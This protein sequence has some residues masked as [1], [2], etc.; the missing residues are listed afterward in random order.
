MKKGLTLIGLVLLPGLSACPLDSL[1]GVLSDEECLDILAGF[2]D[3]LLPSQTDLASLEGAE[4]ICA[5]LD[6]VR[7]GL[8]G[9]CCPQPW[10]GSEE[11]VEDSEGLCALLETQLVALTAACDEVECFTD[12]DCDDSVFCNGPE[13]CDTQTLQCMP[14]ESPCQAD[15][16]CDEATANCVECLSDPDCDDAEFCNGPE[17]CDTQTSQCLAGTPPCIAACDEQSQVCGPTDALAM[18]VDPD[19]SFSTIDVLDV[20]EEVVRFDTSAQSII[21]AANSQAFQEGN[22]VVDGNFLGATGMFQVR[23]GTVDGERR[24]Y[25][26]ETVPATICDIF[27]TDQGIRIVATSVPVPGN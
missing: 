4:E 1:S 24:A 18:F 16:V 7:R 2:A 11:G 3:P 26:T 20:D 22:W 10:L 25:F 14:A 8:S 13:P 15:L 5:A 19:S 21:W 17:S 6:N 12:E 27:V 23:F 9:G